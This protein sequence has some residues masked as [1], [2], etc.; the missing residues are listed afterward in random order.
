MTSIALALLVACKASNRPEPAPPAPSTASSAATETLRFPEPRVRYTPLP[1]W[2]NRRAEEAKAFVDA[3]AGARWTKP[4]EGELFRLSAPRGSGFI[5]VGLRWL[6][7]P[8]DADPVALLQKVED[9]DR[10]FYAN[11]PNQYVAT[12]PPRQIRNEQGIVGA[13]LHS[14]WDRAGNGE[15]QR[16]VQRV[17][18]KNGHV[19]LLHCDWSDRLGEAPPELSRILDAL[20]FD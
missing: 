7:M 20:R 2:A 15:W 13:E 11:R 17:F 3:S 14:R 18:V 4:A 5:G 10:A 6:P 9:A 8:D 1:G 12:V 16:T 19:Y